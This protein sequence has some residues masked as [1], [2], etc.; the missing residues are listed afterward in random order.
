[1]PEVII[2]NLKE[3]MELLKAY[4]PEQAKIIN[5]RMFVAAAAVRNEARALIPEGDALVDVNSKKGKGKAGWGQ[6]AFSRDGR[7]FGFIGSWVKSNIKV[8]RAGNR[9]KGM[10]VSNFIG[11]YQADPAGVIF[12]TAGHAAKDAQGNRKRRRVPTSNKGESF[13]ANMTNKFT[14][15]RGI[16]AAF[17]KD[18]GKSVAL[19]EGAAREAEALVQ[20]HLNALGG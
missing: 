5:K 18:E 6:W 15:K 4:E 1:M 13:V 9:Y 10:P 20:A 8:T 12:H 2:E 11:V 17:D 14:G 16:W 3:T 19:I 7:D